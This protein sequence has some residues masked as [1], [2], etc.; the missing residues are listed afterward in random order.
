MNPDSDQF[1]EY[2]LPGDE[3][4]KHEMD[5]NVQFDWYRHLPAKKQK[6]LSPTGNHAEAW[7][8]H[9]EDLDIEHQYADQLEPKPKYV[10][11]PGQSLRQY[12]SNK[13]K[14]SKGGNK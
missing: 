8:R 2:R 12:Y 10:K 9:Q 13:N 4:M 6:E 11:M 5:T 7:D 3:P 14:K 1:D